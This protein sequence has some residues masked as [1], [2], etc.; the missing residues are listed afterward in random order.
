MVDWADLFDNHGVKTASPTDKE[1]LAYVTNADQRAA[2]AVAGIEPSFGEEKA[3]HTIGVLFDPSQ[4][5]MQVSYYNSERVGSG[6]VPEARIGQGL[7]RWINVGDQVVIGNIGS[8][9]F[10][11]KEPVPPIGQTF[12]TDEDGSLLTDEDG[13]L[14]T[15]KVEP[16]LDAL[17]EE[18]KA[19]RPVLTGSPV[20]QRRRREILARIEELE[21]ELSQLAPDHGGMGHNRPPQDAAVIAAI[22][23]SAATLRIELAKDEPD[24]VEVA[25]SGSALRN[26][27]S[28]LAGK[29]DAFAE[30]FAKSLGKSLGDAVGK[31]AGVAVLATAISTLVGG[32]L[33]A[34]TWP[35]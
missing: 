13:V 9:A 18:L 15:E 2:L 35:F 3:V 29:A 24:V 25:S 10:V 33:Q 16:D 1:K 30:E 20:E 19:G 5:S 14:L 23:Q 32:W 26:A 11:A 34:I 27:G 7:P 17:M 28:W 6:R 21:N 31:A 4:G 8:R 22:A 12:L